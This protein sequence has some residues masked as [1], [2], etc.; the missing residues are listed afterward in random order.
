MRDRSRPFTPDRRWVRSTDWRCCWPARV[1]LMPPRS[2]ATSRRGSTFS[3]TLSAIARAR[4]RCARSRRSRRTASP[5]CG[6]PA[7]ASCACPHGYGSD[8]DERRG[9]W[10]ARGGPRGELRGLRAVR[11]SNRVAGFARGTSRSARARRCE[12][13]PTALAMGVAARRLHRRGR[14]AERHDAL[15]PR[16]VRRGGRARSIPDRALPSRGRS[17]A[18]STCDDASAARDRSGAAIGCLASRGAPSGMRRFDRSPGA[19]TVRRSAPSVRPRGSARSG[20]ANFCA[21]RRRPARAN[22]ARDARDGHRVTFAVRPRRDPGRSRRRSPRV[23]GAPRRGDSCAHRGRALAGRASRAGGA[24]AR[25]L[26]RAHGPV[27]RGHARTTDWTVRPD[28]RRCRP[29]GDRCAREPPR[30]RRSASLIALGAVLAATSLIAAVM[31]SRPRS[32]VGMRLAQLTPRAHAPRL[33]RSVLVTRD[34]AQSGLGWSESDLLR[35]KI[36]GA[37]A[38]ATLAAAMSLVAPIGPLLVVA[39]AYTGFILPTLRVDRAAGHR[40]S[41][42]EHALVTLVEWAEALVA[43]SRPIEA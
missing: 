4:D 37:L 33:V 19:T 30:G 3:Y 41:E 25:G 12:L 26:S 9:G 36:V 17:V 27:A 35:A 42:A 38:G 32:A 40:R 10:S 14:D 21:S 22:R 16:W 2:R 43:S 31:A 11:S 13:A 34:L 1:S 24:R 7:M 15:A 20:A 29:R 5:P 6:G 39:A 28:P 8:S 18:S 23:R